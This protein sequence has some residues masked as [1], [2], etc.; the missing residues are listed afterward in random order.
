MVLVSVLPKVSSIITF[1][2]ALKRPISRTHHQLDIRWFHLPIEDDY[3]P[4]ADF[5]EAW[6]SEKT[7]INALISGGK[8]IAIHCMGGSGRTGM[9]A[10]QILL[11]RGLVL[12]EVTS[13][14]KNIRST[15]LCIPT[16]IAY[17]EAFAKKI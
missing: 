10:D 15:D 7:E 9:V 5:H 4:G 12:S 6:K 13:R 8:S 14:V 16:Q 3:A 2:I 17:I 1:G 11:E